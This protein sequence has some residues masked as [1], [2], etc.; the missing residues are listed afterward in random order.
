MHL[1]AI[2]VGRLLDAAGLR[3][4][5]LGSKK[6]LDAGLAKNSEGGY[7]LK[8]EWNIQ[9][10]VEAIQSAQGAEEVTQSGEEVLRQAEDDM[11]LPTGTLDVCIDAD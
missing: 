3:E 8:T 7:G 2:A 6:A 10:V 5:K 11:G 1:S 4:G 9:M